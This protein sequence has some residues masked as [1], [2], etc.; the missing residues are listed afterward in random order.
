MIRSATEA[1][2]P[3][4]VEMGR[5]FRGETSYSKY[6]ADNP[7]QMTILAKQLL[8]MGGIVVA[9]I[10]GKLIGMLGYIFHD[11]FISGEKFSGE[12]FW[13]VEPEH[14]GAGLRL[15]SE[16][17]RLS[18]LAGAKYIQ[19]IAPTD[20]VARVYEHCGFEFVESTYQLTL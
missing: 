18:K 12:V 4:M 13:W 6:L 17:K 15:L 7:E 2:I 10:E 9:E 3:R 14:R 1:D 8:G 11:H 5:R 19:M 20:Q 16:A